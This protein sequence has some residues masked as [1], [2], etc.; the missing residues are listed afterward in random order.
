MSTPRTLKLDEAV[1]AQAIPTERGTFAS[2][3][4]A[5]HTTSLPRGNALLVP[6]FTGSKEDFAALL[7]LLAEAG[8]SAATYDQRGQFDS[9]G[10]PD[11]DYTLSGLAA[12]T[13]ALARALFGDEEKVHLVGHS[14]GGLVAA[15]AAIEQPDQWASLT[16]MCSG[17]GGITGDRRRVALD[18]AQT[19]ARE[20]LE[21]AYQINAQRSRERGFAAPDAEIERFLHRRFLSNSA[22]SLAAM[23][24]L[25]ATAPDRTP[26][27]TKL[28]L[29][30][31]V[32]RGA[33]DDAWPHDVQDELAQALGTRVVV[34]ADAA[35]S[36]AVE[37]PQETRD[38]LVRVWLG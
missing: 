38:A 26:E 11:D 3:S 8:W 24:T 7:P 13:S 4:C 33:D 5:P 32:M 22:D 20:G 18:G 9:P 34:I 31:A 12:D 30:I 28:D 29:P 10:E 23:A 36:P 25:L 27:L 6:G 15:T 37:Q 1:R 21:S 17:P 19:I 2:F 16:L 35:H 14:L